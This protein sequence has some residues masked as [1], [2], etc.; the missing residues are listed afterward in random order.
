[1]TQI[2]NKLEIAEQET[3]EIEW[4][5]KSK[6][7][8]KQYEKSYIQVWNIHLYIYTHATISQL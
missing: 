2:L 3:A 8:E 6:N 1:M 5:L 7:S 4:K